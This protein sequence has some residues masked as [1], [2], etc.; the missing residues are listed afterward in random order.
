MMVW[1]WHILGTGTKNKT[2][3]SVHQLLDDEQHFG[4]SHEIVLYNQS[5]NEGYCLKGAMEISIK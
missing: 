1:H 3:A 4:T 2:T 5:R